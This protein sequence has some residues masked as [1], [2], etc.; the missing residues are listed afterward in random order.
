MRVALLRHSAAAMRSTRTLHIHLWT[1]VQ[2][3]RLM[4]R[5]GKAQAVPRAPNDSAT[6]AT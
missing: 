4:R 2:F 1:S 5:A 6:I 3:P